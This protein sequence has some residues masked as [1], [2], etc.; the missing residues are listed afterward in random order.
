MNS[1]RCAGCHGARY[2]RRW[3]RN[4]SRSAKVRLTSIAV[5]APRVSDCATWPRIWND[6]VFSTEDKDSRNCS[7]RSSL[8]VAFTECRSDVSRP[9]AWEAKRPHFQESGADYE[10]AATTEWTSRRT[11]YT[12]LGCSVKEKL[13]VRLTAGSPVKDDPSPKQCGRVRY[14][15]R[16]DPSW[17]CWYR[18]ANFRA[19][20]Q[21]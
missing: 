8:E 17:P 13:K 20:G 6:L 16:K 11:A 18:E 12:C 19:A 5:R 7:S 3:E 1:I 10:D 9:E 14:L 21:E 15:R 4:L 2:R